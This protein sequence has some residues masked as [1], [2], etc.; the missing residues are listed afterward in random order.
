VS[1]G[2]ACTITVSQ[3]AFGMYDPRS[4]APHDSSAAIRWECA[5]PARV[6]L[7]GGPDRQLRGPR[8]SLRY[9]LYLDPGRAQPWG[10]GTRGT[11]MMTLPAGRSGATIFARIHAGQNQ[12]PGTY[13]D[14][15]LVIVQ[16]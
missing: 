2:L 16:F 5:A 14:S 15:V 12:P 9:G 4:Q 8:G 6:L 3:L 1:P 7:D 11:S 13:S 10:D